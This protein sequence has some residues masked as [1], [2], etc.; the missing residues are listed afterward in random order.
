M[1]QNGNR[2]LTLP[3]D[4]SSK[5]TEGE[6]TQRSQCLRVVSPVLLYAFLCRKTGT[7]HC[8][9]G[10]LA[11]LCHPRARITTAAFDLRIGSSVRPLFNFHT[12]WDQVRRTSHRGK[13]LVPVRYWRP[14]VLLSPEKISAGRISRNFL[15]RPRALFL[16]DSGCYRRL[17]IIV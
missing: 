9:K 11:L 7:L 1:T 14:G 17:A 15:V 5:R 12:W 3:R 2:C 6:L 13:G 16:V 8:E 10:S 4:A